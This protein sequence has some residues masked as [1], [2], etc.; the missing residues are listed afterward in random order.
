MDCYEFCLLCEDHF[1]IV[2]TKNHNQILFATSFLCSRINFS[3]HQHKCILDNATAALLTCSEFKTFLC[4]S[5]SNS[6]AFVDNIWGKIKRDSQ[7]QQKDIQD[8]AAHLEY[9]QAILVKFDADGA[10]GKAALICFL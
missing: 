2:E 10:L 9:L 3:W 5:L 8:W 4:K 1:G 7:Y 6:R